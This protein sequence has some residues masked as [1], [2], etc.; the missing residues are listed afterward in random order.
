MFHHLRDVDFKVLSIDEDSLVNRETLNG[1]QNQDG[2][3]EFIYSLVINDISFGGDGEDVFIETP[4]VRSVIN[5]VIEGPYYLSY[6]NE[7]I[8]EQNQE[9]EEDCLVRARDLM[10]M[11]REIVFDQKMFDNILPGVAQTNKTLEKLNRHQRKVLE[12]FTTDGRDPRDGLKS[13]DNNSE[14]IFDKNIDIRERLST[15]KIIEV[16]DTGN[17]LSVQMRSQV[18]PL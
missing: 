11:D 13:F 5:D 8:F 7:L 10:E 3:R 9:L 12:Y 18:M 17:G 16:D 1:E 2:L 15:S 4:Q 14:L 6:D